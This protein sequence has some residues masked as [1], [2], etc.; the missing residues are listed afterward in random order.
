[1]SQGHA[2]S[3]SP[4]RGH[5]L[6]LGGA[7]A[8]EPSH[9]RLREMPTWR[10]RGAAGRP[11]GRLCCGDPGGGHPPPQAGAAAS[12]CRQR[13]Q[14]GCNPPL[15]STPTQKPA[16]K[17]RGGPWLQPVASRQRPW[18]RHFGQCCGS[19]NGGDGRVLWGRLPAQQPFFLGDPRLH[20]GPMQ[21][22][23]AAGPIP[24]QRIP[25]QRIRR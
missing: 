2:T 24:K 10:R 9:G 23:P 15:L 12:S 1:V 21:S 22:S 4:G 18:G 6:G 19:I 7:H 13:C 16:R 14:R 20:H 17:L 11:R 8:G 5:K 25:K 3:A